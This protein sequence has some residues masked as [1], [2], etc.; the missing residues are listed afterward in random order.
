[1]A[2]ISGIDEAGRGP[3]IGPMVL[4]GVVLEEKEIERLENIGVKD[5]KLLSLQ[6]RERMFEQIKEIVKDYK[7]KIVSPEQIDSALNSKAL[8]LNKLE[9]FTAAFLQK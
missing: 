1:M 2:L 4:A 6:Q 5:S 8:N 3:V 7:I 9:G